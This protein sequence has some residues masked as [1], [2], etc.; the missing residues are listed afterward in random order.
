VGKAA[1]LGFGYFVGVVL[2]EPQVG[3]GSGTLSGNHY[4]FC[5]VGHGYFTRPNKV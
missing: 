4:F 5:E 2:D 3:L 1:E